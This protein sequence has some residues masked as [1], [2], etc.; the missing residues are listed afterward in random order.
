MSTQRI[1]TISLFILAILQV[2]AL[3][4]ADGERP[5]KVSFYFAGAI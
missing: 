2:P 4:A 1:V 5:H 3:R